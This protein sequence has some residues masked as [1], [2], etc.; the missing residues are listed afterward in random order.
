MWPP[1]AS[2]PAQLQRT[3]DWLRSRE[4]LAYTE[5][6]T[7]VSGTSPDMARRESGAE[8]ADAIGLGS[9][10]LK[11]LPYRTQADQILLEDTS[12]GRDVILQVASDGSVVHELEVT[13]AG[14]L[15]RRFG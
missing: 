9:P 10:N 14:R 3:M 13:P 15:E 5:T 12:T 2:D 4:S 6:M 8:L 11:L 7:T 1:V